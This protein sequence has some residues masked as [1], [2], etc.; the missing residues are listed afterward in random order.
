MWK[1]SYLKGAWSV[2]VE[3]IK[4]MFSHLKSLGEKIQQ[5]LLDIQFLIKPENGKKGSRTINTQRIP[6]SIQT[7]NSWV[8]MLERD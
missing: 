2:Q 6:S 7:D 5:T 3:N 8:K 1:L 4:S